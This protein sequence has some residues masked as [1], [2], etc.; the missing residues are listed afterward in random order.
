M[1][2][3]INTY[4]DDFTIK[5]AY[6]LLDSLRNNDSNKSSK[7]QVPQIKIENKKTHVLNFRELCVTMNRSEAEVQIFLNDELNCKTSIDQNGVLLLYN[8][9]RSNIIQQ[10]IGNY[11]KR[12]LLCQQC[13]STDTINI[14]EKSFTYIECNNCKSKK[15]VEKTIVNSKN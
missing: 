4:S 9:Y 6:R 10:N 7:F 11:I 14:K 8:I 3:Q 2:E 1:I 15:C 13:K 5:R 12:F